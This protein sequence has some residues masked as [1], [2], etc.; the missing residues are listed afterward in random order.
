MLACEVL[1]VWVAPAALGHGLKDGPRVP[2]SCSPRNGLIQ[3]DGGSGVERPC[4]GLVSLCL[5][6][7][8]SIFVF[9]HV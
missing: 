3:G 9:L 7:S 8:D 1:G 6:I 2:S 4:A 5:C